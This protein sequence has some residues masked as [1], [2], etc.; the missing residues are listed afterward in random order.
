MP[1]NANVEEGGRRGVRR[2]DGVRGGVEKTL[3][4]QQCDAAHFQAITFPPRQQL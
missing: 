3:G 2:W 4:A 1:H